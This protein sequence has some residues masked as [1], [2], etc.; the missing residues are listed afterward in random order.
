MAAT[1]PDEPANYIKTPGGARR[2]CLKKKTRTTPMDA[3]LR[4]GLLQSDRTLAI[5]RSSALSGYSLT[6]HPQTLKTFAPIGVF[7]VYSRF[8]LLL[9]LLAFTL[10]G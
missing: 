3:N 1:V 6:I 10:P 8:L 7:R 2:A 5:T 9:R 4:D